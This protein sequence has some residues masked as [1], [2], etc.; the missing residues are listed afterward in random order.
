MNSY[1]V[2]QSQIFSYGEYTIV[3]IRRE[4]RHAIMRWRN[5]QIYHLRQAKPLTE[6]DQDQY[7]NSVVA[8]LFEQEKPSQILFSYLKGDQLIGYGG[9]V[10]I[11]WLD[12]N[13]EISFIMDT[14]L[15]GDFFEQNW[16]LFLKLIEQVA[17]ENLE[18]HKIFTYAFDI[19]PHLYPALEKSGFGLEAELKEHCFFEGQFI[20]VKIHSKTN[21]GL[22]LRKVKKSDLE[23]TF[24]WANNPVI[25]AF[26]FN[27]SPIPIEEHSRWFFS[28]LDSAECEFYILEVN[29]V[30]AGSIRFDIEGDDKAKINYLIDPNFTGKGLGTAILE[31]GMEKLRS[32]RPDLQLIYGLVL[33]ENKAS[34][35][36]FE[37]LSFEE[38]LEDGTELKYEKKLK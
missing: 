37:K 34:K 2:L 11:N 31:K 17:F 23:I 24:S 26:S 5:E 21:K 35:R 13:A 16:I 18:L 3:P 6:K 9:L 12:K 27:T 8:S 32:E 38:T 15:E 10:H 14:D 4:D 36:I 28:K 30:P 25:R 20:S 22:I 29:G 7:F 33:Q 1:K 19:R